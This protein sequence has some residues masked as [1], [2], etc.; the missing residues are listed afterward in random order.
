M[1]NFASSSTL[2]TAL[3]DGH[4]AAS[5]SENQEDCSLS[6]TAPLA[7]QKTMKMMI[8]HHPV[9][10][11]DR[12]NQEMYLAKINTIFPQTS[13]LDDKMMNKF[14]ASISEPH[15]LCKLSPK[16]CS[17]WLI[18]FQKGISQMAQT[19]RQTDTLI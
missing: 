12:F 7:A 9:S 14:C 6:V 8:I 4:W 11:K 2:F 5:P 3:Q 13:E 17:D 1:E 15:N 10:D 19:H 18:N 16:L